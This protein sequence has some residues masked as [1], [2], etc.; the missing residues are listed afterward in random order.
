MKKVFLAA[1]AS[2]AL[3][4]SCVSEELFRPEIDSSAIYASI[5][6][7]ALTRT[8]KDQDN[9]VLW[10]DD[11]RIVAFMN[12]TQGT[13]Y[14][15]KSGG[16]TTAGF[17]KV[18]SDD[19]MSGS[20]ID[21]IVAYYPYSEDI[22][23][24]EVA[25]AY[26]MDVVLPSSQSYVPE[27]FGCGSFPMAAVSEDANLTFRNV[28]GAMKLQLKGSQKV[29]SVKVD[30]KNGEK[31]SGAATVTAYA[32]GDKPSIVMSDAASTFVRLDCGEGVQL[33][34]SVVTEF[35][36]ALPP[37]LFS[38]GFTVTVTDTD[39]KTYTVKTDKANEVRRSSVL[40]MPEVALE[41][42]DT[43]L[44][45]ST[46]E[47]IDENGVNQGRGVEIDGVIWAP[48][49]CGYHETD[50][51]CGKL[52]QWGRKY[53][54]GYSGYYYNLGKDVSDATVPEIREGGVSL[55]GGQS[56]EN[57]NVFF[58][59]DP[60]NYDD[61]VYP[62]DDTLWN[63]G[64]EEEPVKTEYDP[65]PDGWRVP[66]YSELDELSKNKSSLTT[67]DKQQT[68]Y[69]L[70][71]QSS[72]TSSVPQVFFP[73]AGYRSCIDGTANCRGF[74]GS[75]W[76]LSPYDDGSAFYLSL[77]FY[78][79][80]TYM[81]YSS[82]ANGYSVR[83][84]YD[85]NAV[86]ME[87]P[88]PDDN[89]EI[90][91]STVI[92]STSSLKLYEGNVAQLTTKLRPSD[93]TDATVT[94]SSDTPSV[95]TVDQSGLVTGISAG[96]ATITAVAGG[97]SATCSVTVSSL[98]VATANYVDEYGKDRGKGIVVGMTVWAPVNCGYHET[99][100]PYGKLYQWGRKYGQ[101]YSGGL[102]DGSF[103]FL[104]DV[105]DATVP[106]IREGG[107]SLAGG[108]SEENANVFFLAD[109]ENNGDWVYPSDDTL[110]NSGTEED[111]VKTEYDPCPDGWRVP[112]YAE[113][114]YLRQ[115]KSSWTTNDK[116]QEGYWLSGQSS[117]TSS[118]P[119]VFFPAAGLRDC[120]D[121][122][123]Y[124][125]GYCGMYWS[126]SPLDN[127]AFSLF[128]YDGSTDMSFSLCAYGFSVRCVQENK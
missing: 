84:V 7:M 42:Q 35:I 61:W 12:N 54:Q 36:I 15:V 20:Y 50:Y 16:K 109:S 19:L 90:P 10:S 120:Y 119:Q 57:A 112:T 126:S 106:E 23:C 71:G 25:G 83:C 58:L 53:G 32:G 102:Y 5:E 72:Y 40:I 67:N 2:A 28:C 60:E 17:T 63:S 9:R 127:Y 65:C 31:L 123:A 86:G 22:E 99:D 51:P 80:S 56:D 95:A 69:W 47:Y 13:Q 3:F 82:R 116:N 111:P 44:P 122:N 113:L 85:E 125:R 27:S 74:D 105:S 49:N 98:A 108:Q 110:W 76:S 115:N 66:T 121:G 8:S 78:D 79:G 92:I 39:G 96:K 33:S 87:W 97:V 34:E 21:H 73:A 24:E 88:V 30:G 94:W 1:L 37:V 59:G 101:G 128:F 18:L 77:F 14:K 43:P 91:V 11:D 118:V 124:Y 114:D 100:Y 45:D 48:V 104:G 103:N 29:A 75:Y 117:Y 55:A 89:V 107:V 64:T 81:S 4:S 62:S 6:S 41:E 70:S 52:Y 38:E 26:S 68:G 46:P 93:A